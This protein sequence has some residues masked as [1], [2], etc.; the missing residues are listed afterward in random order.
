MC[1]CRHLGDLGLF[2]APAHSVVM[3]HT[4]L[5]AAANLPLKAERDRDGRPTLVPGGQ[6]AEGFAVGER[7][8]ELK[9]KRALVTL[10]VHAKYL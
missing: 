1:H 7:E 8:A 4:G 2:L 9:W 3:I 10:A 5:V 6:L